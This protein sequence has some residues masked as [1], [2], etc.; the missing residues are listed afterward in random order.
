MA[1]S[2]R[3]FHVDEGAYESFVKNIDPFGDEFDKTAKSTVAPHV[4]LAGD[5]FSVMGG[6]SGFSGAYSGRMAELE[7][8]MGRLGGK[9]RDMADAARRTRAN[10]DVMEDDHT[11]SLRDIGKAL[12]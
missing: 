1:E 3:G 7:E 9:W 12:G 4:E 6:E 2:H 10:Y 11:G 8:R 5:G